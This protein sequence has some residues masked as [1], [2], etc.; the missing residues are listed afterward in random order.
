MSEQKTLAE[1]IRAEQVPAERDYNEGLRVAANMVEAAARLA[2]AEQPA[3]A[4]PGEQRLKEIRERA[5]KAT[6]RLITAWKACDGCN[7][8]MF[9]FGVAR[10]SENPMEGYPVCDSRLT[11]A[12]LTLFAHARQDVLDLAAEVSRL[13]AEVQAARQAKD[14]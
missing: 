8:A 10:H 12:D 6:P 4:E 13:T 2:E 1:R 7:D 3:P 14:E 11:E 5:E 9:F